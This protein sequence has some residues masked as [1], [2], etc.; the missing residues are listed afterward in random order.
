MLVLLSVAVIVA[1]ERGIDMLG[2]RAAHY[3]HLSVEIAAAAGL[4]GFGVVALSGVL[5]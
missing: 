4:A 1:K 5:G 3:T 2:G